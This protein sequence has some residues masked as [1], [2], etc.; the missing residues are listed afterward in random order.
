MFSSSQRDQIALDYFRAEGGKEHPACPQCGDDLK[1][2]V[3][4]QAL[5]DIA[6]SVGCPGCQQDF[7]WLPSRLPQ[8]FR[9]MDL[10]YFQE[11]LSEDRPVRCPH[12]DAI[13]VCR[14]F[15]D[16]VAEFRCPYCNRCGS[17]R[18]NE[19]QTRDV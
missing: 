14:R 19:F 15:S 10:I 7:R 8:N 11:C 12:D 4:Y 6:L 18:W 13:I 17:T 16:G 9:P 2:D 1:I 5:P 3:D